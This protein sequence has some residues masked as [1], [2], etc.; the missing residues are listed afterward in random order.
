[1]VQRVKLKCI[2]L[3]QRRSVLSSL[4]Y[5]R[6]TVTTVGFAD[7]LK[8]EVGQEKNFLYNSLMSQQNK[9]NTK[10]NKRKV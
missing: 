5:A 3:S 4:G 10:S 7:P 1:M 2:F 6:S 8:S 9:T